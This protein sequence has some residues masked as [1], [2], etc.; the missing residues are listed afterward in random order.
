[1]LA[2]E[3]V[4]AALDRALDVV[5]EGGSLHVIDFG[6]C[7]GWP[8]PFKSA[9]RRWLAA[10]DVTPREDLAET[11]AVLSSARGLISKTED[12]RGGYARLAVARPGLP[13][14]RQS[15]NVPFSGQVEMSPFGERRVG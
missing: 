6:G 5:A 4:R 8:K 3:R 12:W 9:L 13:L 14:S 1:M 15:R 11:L 10:F 2:N 7:A